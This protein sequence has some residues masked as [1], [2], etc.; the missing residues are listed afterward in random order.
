M[1]N[2]IEVKI[3]QQSLL[4][5]NADNYKEILFWIWHTHDLTMNY[6]ALHNVYK[7]N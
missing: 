7:P 4:L 3:Q 2:K 6:M 5:Y 1:L